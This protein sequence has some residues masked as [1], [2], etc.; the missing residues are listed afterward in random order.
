LKI[1]QKYRFEY[2]S[3]TRAKTP[4][5]HKQLNILELP[6]DLPCFE[7]I[8]PNRGVSI[9]SGLMK[10]GHNHILPVHAEVEGGLFE[11][12]F[13]E[14]LKSVLMTE[15][16]IVKLSEMKS[17]IAVDNLPKRSFKMELLPGRH[18]LCAV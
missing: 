3:C 2:L 1:I 13:R 18:S 8:D 7:E 9:I 14:I 12:K 16:K 10:D 11:D 6:S 5:I 17:G 4:F 15:I